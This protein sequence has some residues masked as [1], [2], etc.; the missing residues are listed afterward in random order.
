MVSIYK[1]KCLDDRQLTQHYQAL[2]KPGFEN[3]FN[4]NL[5]SV[6]QKTIHA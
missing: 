3:K 4:Q 1:L 6:S 5:V 2:F